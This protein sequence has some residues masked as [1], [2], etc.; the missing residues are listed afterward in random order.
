MLK[1][2]LPRSTAMPILID[3][4]FYSSALRSVEEVYARNWRELL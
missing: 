4:C 3:H 2:F 1:I